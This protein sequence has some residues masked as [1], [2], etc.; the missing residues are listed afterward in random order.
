MKEVGDGNINFVYIV[1]G[2]NG[3]VCVKQALP[4]VRCVGESWP[5]TQDRLRLE[6]TTNPLPPRPCL[7]LVASE[8]RAFLFPLSSS[9]PLAPQREYGNRQTS[10][11]LHLQAEAMR[12]QAEMCPAHVPEIYHYDPKWS[13]MVMK[14][15]APPHIILRHSMNQA[16][17]FP[18][19]LQIHL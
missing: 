13:V 15:L 14:Y 5:L 7:S 3:A 11:G 17:H 8:S 16:W 18:S 10:P 9:R 19:T 6:V 4:F 12:F 1:E 2:P